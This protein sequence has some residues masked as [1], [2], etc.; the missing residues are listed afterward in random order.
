MTQSLFG[1]LVFPGFFFLCL[2]GA[3]AEYFDRIF[4]ARMQNR[5][6]PPWFQPVADFI[7]LSAKEDIV[8]EEA[9]RFMFKAMP[10]V[11]VASAVTAVLYI[12]LWTT[13]AMYAFEGDLIIVLYLLTIPTMAFFLA[14]WYSTSLY[15]AVGAVRTLTQLFA[16]EVPLYISV[17][18]PAVL[19]NTWSLSGMT[20]YYA[21]HPGYWLFNLLGFAV[22][23]VILLGKLEKVPFDIPEAETEI[24]S[25]VFTE[26]GG[27]FLAFFRM[28]ID[29]EAVVVA[30]LVATV[31]LPFGLGLPA[32][33]GFFLYMVK[34]ALVIAA[35]SFLR[36]IFAR[37]RIEQ[38]VDFCWKYLAP[39]A[40]VQMLINLILKGVL[41]Q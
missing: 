13:Q 6:G 11:A 41:P 4:H 33:I 20:K 10:V 2:I 19:A 21:A 7:K 17:L 14:G 5:K 37:L 39:A 22:S 28:A 26:Y 35:V 24:V 15:A 12:P 27:R 25:G 34:V 29:I 16:Y 9:D 23:L 18:A 3:C 40:I 38:M 32:C 1:M 31:F 8:P 30:S 36:T